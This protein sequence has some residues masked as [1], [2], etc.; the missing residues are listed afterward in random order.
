MKSIIWKGP[1]LLVLGGKNYAPSNVVIEC[2]IEIVELLDKATY[3]VVEY[4]KNIEVQIK[5]KLNA[6][7]DG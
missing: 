5:K 6:R 7:N 1:G 4:K 2:P 3:T